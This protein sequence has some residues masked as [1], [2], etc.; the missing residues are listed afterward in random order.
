[1][2][3][4][5]RREYVKFWCDRELGALELLRA[6]YITHAFPPHAHE[7][8]AIGIIEGGGQDFT[9]QR[10]H[11]LVMPAGTVAVI[12]PG[13]VHT[14]RAATDAGWTYRMLYPAAAIL[15][16]VASAISGRSRDVPFFP[17]PV[18][19]DDVLVQRI[20][21]LHATLED[22]TTTRL[23][24]ESRLWWVLAQLIVRHADT[25]HEPRSI[26]P[27]PAYVAQIRAFLHEHV[28]EPITLEQLAQQV[29]LSPF[30]LLRVFRA[31]VGLPPHAYLIQLRVERAKK[32]L[33]AGLPIADI[34]V[35]TGFTDQS[36]LSRHFKRMVGV[37]PGQYRQTRSAQYHPRL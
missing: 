3:P 8:F 5:H 4:P 16:R 35:Q 22:P 9:Y 13:V 18:I 21:L 25:A 11:H 28:A 34:A 19:H 26:A 17:T 31:A 20:Q 36:H 15:Q 32:L 14:G 12:N 23:E 30:H 29:H 7:G 37:P 6:T 27:E 1:M 2:Q 10:T 24:R 33:L